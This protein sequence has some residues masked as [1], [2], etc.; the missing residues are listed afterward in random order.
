MTKINRKSEAKGRKKHTGS[1]RNFKETV[2]IVSGEVR[3]DIEHM[4]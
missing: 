2:H 3:E 1:G 4:K